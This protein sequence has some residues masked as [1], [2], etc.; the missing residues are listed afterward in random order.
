M[1]QDQE[2]L[3]KLDEAVVTEE[4]LKKYKEDLPKNKRVVEVGK[5]E[6]KTVRRLQG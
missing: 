2:K 4:Q 6:F 1:E 3:Q 5:D